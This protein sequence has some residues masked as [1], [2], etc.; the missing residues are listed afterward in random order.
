[1]GPFPSSKGNKY[2]LV[3]VDYVSKRVEAIVSPTDDSRIVAKLFKRIIFP[4]FRVPRVLISDNRTH[5]IKKKL[6]A[7]LKKYGMHHKYGLCYP[8]TRGQVE[9]SNRKIKLIL[10]KTVARSPKDWVDKLD[11][12]LWTYR[13]A[14]KTPIGT[15]P[16]RLVYGKS[17]HLSVELEHKVM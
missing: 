10:E 6:K 14:F 17:C 3:A 5:C 7:L 16:F 4:H 8:Q 1:M 13:T 11:D 15:N 9:I 12:T 2:I